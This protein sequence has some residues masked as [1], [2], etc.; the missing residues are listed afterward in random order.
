MSL[1]MVVE[2]FIFCYTF[3]FLGSSVG[4]ACPDVSENNAQRTNASVRDQIARV[5]SD[6]TIKAL[7]CVLLNLFTCSLNPLNVNILSAP[8][9]LCILPGFSYGRLVTAL[10]SNAPQPVPA[11]V[12]PPVH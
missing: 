6:R 1:Q 5:P 12:C 7:D 11:L 8:A 4:L 2:V 9:S 10:K 3:C